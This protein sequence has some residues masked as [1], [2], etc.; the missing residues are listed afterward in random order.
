MDR[1]SKEVRSK[2]MKEVRSKKQIERYHYQSTLAARSEISQKRNVTDLSG[3]PDIAIKKY[4]IVI[5]IDSCFWHGCSENKTI[6]KT[7]AE[8]LGG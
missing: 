4:R 7:N 6:P 1:V 8:F 2:N 5:F 3:K